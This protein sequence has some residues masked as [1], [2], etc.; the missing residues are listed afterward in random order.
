MGRGGGRLA[1]SPA[2]TPPGEGLRIRFAGELLGS[3]RRDRER[4]ASGNVASVQ[5]GRGIRIGWLF[6]RSLDLDTDV[7]HQ[8][9]SNEL[10]RRGAGLLPIWGR[11]QESYRIVLAWCNPC[12]PMESTGG[13]RPTLTGTMG[14]CSLGWCQVTL[15]FDGV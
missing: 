10:P 3:L 7:M 2:E 14:L 8:L 6:R 15:S 9:G 5:I 4:D 11:S 1:R 12:I 13:V